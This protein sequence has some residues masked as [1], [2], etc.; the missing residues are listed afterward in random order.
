MRLVFL[1][2]KPDQQGALCP[3]CGSVSILS[4]VPARLAEAGRSPESGALWVAVAALRARVSSLRILKQEHPELAVLA[5][6]VDLQESTG[7][8]SDSSSD[9]SSSSSSSSSDSDS[10]VRLHS[11]PSRPGQGTLEK[12]EGTLCLLPRREQ[13]FTFFFQELQLPPV[14]L[15]GKVCPFYNSEGVC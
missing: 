8:A 12:P 3:A 11:L 15:W 2:G 13:C 7:I 5:D 4:T 1:S 14:L 10:E 9:S 6:S